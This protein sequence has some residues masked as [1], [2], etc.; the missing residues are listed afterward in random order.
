MLRTSLALYTWH[1]CSSS[2]N[3]F[4]E[5]SS[6]YIGD[7][8]VRPAESAFLAPF[9]GQFSVGVSY[10]PLSSW[11]MSLFPASGR[12]TYVRSGHL[13][14]AGAFGLQPAPR[15]ENGQ[16]LAPARK[17]LWEV[18]ARF[19]SNLE[20]TLFK[21]LTIKHF[22]DIFGSY[23]HKPWGPVVFSQ[24]QAA[25]QLKGFLALTL[26]QQLIYDPRIVRGPETLQLLTTWGIGIT[27]KA[28]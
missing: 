9:Y 5:M 15:D 12:V 13:A 14:D 4:Y 6:S 21:T 22:L 11:Q 26:S 7:S 25:Y 18:G 27:Y 23:S 10:K 28:P 3:A 24:L 1:V 16:L 19:T 17:T 8:I 20:L 2:S